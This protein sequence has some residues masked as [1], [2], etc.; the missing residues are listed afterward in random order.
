MLSIAS[1]ILLAA[2]DRH[3]LVAYKPPNMPVQEDASGD[4]DMLSLLKE[5]IR[6]RDAK[7][8]NVYLGLLHRLDRPARGLLV[9]AKTSKAAARL[10]ASQREGAWVKEYLAV[11]RGS[12]AEAEGAFTDWLVK[13]PHT[14]SSRVVRAD[15]AL[16]AG[17]KEARL[18]WSLAARCAEPEELS[19]VQI[20]LGTGRSHQIR[21][22][23]CARGFPL[24][25][26]ARYD[27]ARNTAGMQLALMAARLEFPHPISGEAC[28][29]ALPE[30]PETYPWNVF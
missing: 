26:D 11:A 22:Q 7:P 24:W 15:G 9:F 16:P 17:A 2:E 12:I 28:A 8:G 30:K 6:Q 3:F 21:V 27:P 13:D 25:G 19:L 14:H 20:R 4:P 5:Y 10:S 23:F 29:Y 1:G 18:T